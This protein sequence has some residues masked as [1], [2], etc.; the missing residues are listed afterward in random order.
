MSEGDDWSSEEEDNE[1]SERSGGVGHGDGEGAGESLK[2][3][4]RSSANEIL[5]IIFVLAT[6]DVGRGTWDDWK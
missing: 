1:W 4:A 3:D 5:I 2:C 6:W